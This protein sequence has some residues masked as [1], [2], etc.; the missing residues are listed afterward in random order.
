MAT[1]DD[2]LLAT[3]TVAQTRARAAER[4]LNEAVIPERDVGRSWQAISDVLGMTYQRNNRRLHV[5]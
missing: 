5:V 2:P 3:I 4:A 1:V